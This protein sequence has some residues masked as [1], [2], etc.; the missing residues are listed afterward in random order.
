L[1]ALLIASSLSLVVVAAGCGGGSSTLPADS[2]VRHT[3][4]NGVPGGGGG[5]AGGG[6]ATPLP[7]PSG[8]VPF[9]QIPPPRAVDGPAWFFYDTS[10]LRAN[11]QAPLTINYDTQPGING[12]GQPIGTSRSASLL[13][14]NTSKKT[15]LTITSISVVGPNAGDFNLDPA[16]LAIAVGAPVPAKNDS[17]VAI[18]VNFVPTA[19]GVRNASIQFVSNAGTTLI[20]MVGSAL[21]NR[22]IVTKFAPLNFIPTSAPA[23]LQMANSGGLTLA[24]TSVT[25]TGPDAASFAVFP[26]QG[27]GLGSCGFP[28]TTDATPKLFGAHQFCNFEVGLNPGATAPVT[29]VLTIQSNDPL[30]PLENVPLTLNP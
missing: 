2:G 28:T 19:E 24:I 15:A 23:I 30:T 16:F 29:A 3:Q 22:P 20:P 8:P 6:G 14:Y 27:A 4:S 26:T 13:V 21:P 5:G 9:P 10:D 1:R 18:K 11:A 7:P 12:V 17:A 25:I